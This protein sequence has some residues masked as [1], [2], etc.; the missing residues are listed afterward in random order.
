MLTNLAALPRNLFAIP[1]V[2]IPTSRYPR[3]KLGFFQSDA[4]PV[5]NDAALLLW[6]APLFCAPFREDDGAAHRLSTALKAHFQY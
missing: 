3:E 2:K 1:N 6:L 4:F 5:R